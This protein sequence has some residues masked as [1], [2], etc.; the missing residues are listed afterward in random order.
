MFDSSAIFALNSS[1]DVYKIG[2]DILEFYFVTTR[3]KITIN[4]TPLVIALVSELDGIK[5]IGDICGNIGLDSQNDDVQAFL[6]Y[7]KENKVLLLYTEEEKKRLSLSHD[8]NIRYDRQLTYFDSIAG[9]SAFDFQRKLQH[10]RVL[11]FGVGAIGSGIALQLVMAG[12]R[13]FIFVDKDTVTEDSIE[14]HFA[15]NSLDIG[16]TKVDALAN[17]LKTIDK[18]V[19]CETYFQI[20]DFDSALDE[21]LDKSDF[22]VNT[23]DEPYIGFTSMKI[24][25]ACYKRN[26]PLYVAGGF[27]AHL[28]STGELIIPDKT[29]C[30]DCYI[31]YFT[32]S[33][34]DWKPKYNTEAISEK[35][36]IADVFE[37]GGLAS[38]SLFSISYASIVILNYLA[39][40][41]VESTRGRGELLFD[42]HE[43]KY[44]NVPKNPNC[45]V[46]GNKG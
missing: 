4:V 40:G 23:L 39:T 32:D 28:M 17:Y 16:K 8:D 5:S 46:C 19:K 38:M 37:V 35:E 22:V 44:F 9:T 42:G 10:I 33:L 27:D 25:R 18:N 41:N 20:V 24:G 15:F 1:V 12:I 6:D 26:L 30:V 21:L 29:P 14:R 2:N 3:R 11:I 45:N 43:I 36:N 34:L 7:L 13:N 31:K